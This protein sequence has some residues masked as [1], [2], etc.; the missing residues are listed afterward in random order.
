MPNYNRL[1]FCGHLCRDPN[2]KY[3]PN[4]T[5]CTEIALACNR[6]WK[7][8]GGVEHTEVCY[9]DCSLFGR[10]AETVNHYCRKGS[11]VLIEGRLKYDVWDG[12][13]GKKHAK[14]S[15]VVER[16]Q[17][18]SRCDGGQEPAAKPASGQTP[19]PFEPSQSEEDIPF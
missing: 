15:A 11:C 10:Q 8:A 5:A 2:L 13:D 12:A 14:L 17:F 9:I 1:I 4:Q 6:V 7:D 18:I 16:L 3:L 19:P